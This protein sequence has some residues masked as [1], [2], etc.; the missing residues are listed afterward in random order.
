MDRDFRMIR[1]MKSGD[2]AAMEQFIRK[3]YPAIWR[4]CS[5]HIADRCRAEDLTQ[6]TFVRFFGALPKYD[7]C[8]KLLN[9]LYVIAGN[10][11]KNEYRNTNEA[12]ISCFAESEERTA[13]RCPE[14]GG[15]REMGNPVYADMEETVQRL[16]MKRALDAMLPELREV[17]ILYYFQDLKQREIASILGIGVSLVKY[18]L[19]RAKEYLQEVLGEDYRKM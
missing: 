18:R 11:C 19:R 4:Y 3:Y 8:G 13:V 15:S 5:H 14:T 6:E 16:D 7:H 2:E 12:E 17:V 9:Y 10:L 1:K